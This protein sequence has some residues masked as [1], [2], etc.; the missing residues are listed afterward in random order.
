MG[1]IDTEIG[2]DTD[3]MAEMASSLEAKARQL[4]F[5]RIEAFEVL[6]HAKRPDDLRAIVV[7]AEWS[8]TEAA[9]VRDRRQLLVQ[10][11]NQLLWDVDQLRVAGNDSRWRPTLEARPIATVSAELDA[12]IARLDGSASAAAVAAELTVEL[13]TATR[14]L[15]LM[16]SPTP[17]LEL[18]AGIDQVI[19]YLRYEIAKS[20]PAA[21]PDWRAVR[22]AVKGVG[23]HL[24]ESWLRDVDRNDLL[25]INGILA[26]L[27]PPE[28]ELVI[29]SLED[30]QLYR[31]FRELDGL[32]GGNLNLDEEADLFAFVAT[33]VPATALFRLAN[34]EHGGK[35][36]ELA[37]AVRHR[38]PLAAS[39]EF[40]EICAA[41]AADSDAALVAAV[42]G[43]GALGEAARL[44][45]FASLRRNGLAADLAD[46]TRAFLRRRSIERD[47]PIIVEFFEGLLAGLGGTLDT[48]ADL[49]V[50][51]LVDTHEF[52][53]AW[54]R[55]GGAV[56][57]IPTDPVSFAA[58]VLEVDL[59]ARNPANWL[60]LVTADIGSVGLGKLAR[61]GRLGSLAKSIADRL[62]RLASAAAVRLGKLEI[63]RGHVLAAID[64]LY[65]AADALEVRTALDELEELGELDG[66]GELEVD[67]AVPHP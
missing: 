38:A 53:E 9:N 6:A 49:T 1:S 4:H 24:D 46:A 5:E 23:R 34:A 41:H 20:V 47:D 2:W 16:S 30:A 37:A 10:A 36:A 52:R 65:A 44:T 19:N 51:A 57:T 43:I 12:A 29:E 63:E 26:D 35:F 3:R 32:A 18:I 21:S 25:A 66:V 17:D 14:A 60:G 15:I 8:R 13:A 61:L 62:K 40:I 54:S 33:T 56:M 67:L 31:W 22:E 28:I 42:T 64:R 7:A 58:A 45:L 48:L 59:L 55:L 50:I 27:S 39:L 11:E